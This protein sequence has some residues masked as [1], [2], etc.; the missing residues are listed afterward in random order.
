[1]VSGMDPPVGMAAP[2]L[3]R[4]AKSPPKSIDGPGARGPVPG[5][6]VNLLL[7]LLLPPCPA[8]TPAP[9]RPPTLLV[10]ELARAITGSVNGLLPTDA[11]PAMLPATP[12]VNN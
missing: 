6:W 12:A 3:P 9:L 8:W 4:G 10:V 7:L 2:S 1:M 11:A 5:T